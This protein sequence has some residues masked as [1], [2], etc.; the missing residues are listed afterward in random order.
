MKYIRES[1]TQYLW[2]FFVPPGSANQA[3]KKAR[4]RASR[5][6]TTAMPMSDVRCQS[7]EVRAHA[8]KHTTHECTNART[9]HTYTIPISIHI[10][11]AT[12]EHES[13]DERT[14]ANERDLYR[15]TRT[16]PASAHLRCQHT[17]YSLEYQRNAEALPILTIYVLEIL[18]V[19]DVLEYIVGEFEKGIRSDMQSVPASV[20]YWMHDD[21]DDDY[22]IPCSAQ[23]FTFFYSTYIIDRRRQRR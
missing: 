8:R 18:R 1:S 3:G 23:T 15:Y 2:F 22:S 17:T 12:I 19:C 11:R 6:T 4:A 21:N 20:L 10:R 7:V 9:R 13:N 14:N 5:K 16:L